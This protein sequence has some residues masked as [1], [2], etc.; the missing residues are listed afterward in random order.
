M[1]KAR[2]REQIAPRRFEI[3]LL[4][5]LFFVTGAKGQDFSKVIGI[6]QK[7]ESNLKARIAEEEKARKADYDELRTQ[8]RAL[9][10][11][12]P[13]MGLAAGSKH[14]KGV[15]GEQF[16]PRPF[17]N[18][19]E[20][21]NRRFV[22]GKLSA[23]DFARQRPEL[24]SDQHPYAVVLTCSDSRVPPELLFD[25]SLGQLFVIR[26]AGNI[27]D[28]VVLG[29]IEYAAEHLHVGLIVVLGHESCGA[30]KAT[31]AGGDVPPNIGSLVWRIKPAVDRMKPSHHDEKELTSASV[32]ENVRRQI[33]EALVQSNVLRE[34]NEKGELRIVGAV[35]DLESGKVSFLDSAENVVVSEQT[36]QQASTPSDPRK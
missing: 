21:G 29:S 16:D 10:G 17:L 1:N 26:N 24:T 23:K 14:Q 31:I 35:Y 19:L 32:A 6:L 34:M 4:A 22:E 20:T 7:M 12:K 30:V 25:E 11:G 33:G 9:Q 5:G 2:W 27:V 36:N 8:L 28:S 15:E 18:R 13:A 3:V